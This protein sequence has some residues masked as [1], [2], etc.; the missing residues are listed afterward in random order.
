[1]GEIQSVLYAI[2]TDIDV[3]AMYYNKTMFDKYKLP[4]PDW[5][6][7]WSKYVDVA[8]KM[9]RDLN[10]DGSIDQWGASA[11]VWWQSYVYQNGGTILSP[12][13]TKCTLDKPAACGGLQFMSDLVNKYHV[14]PSAEES[15]NVGNMKLFTS[16]K[17]GM[18]ISGSWAA[19]LVFKKEIKDFV[20]M[21]LR[22]PGDRSRGRRLSEEQPTEYWLARHT[23]RKPGNWSSG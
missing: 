19:E 17:I 2:P 5:T 18:F 20:T 3:Y 9:T 16:G 23:K 12:D 8:K 13:E 22:F 21:L 14:A 4:Y 15:A 11:D 6:W 7:N 1:M 10:G